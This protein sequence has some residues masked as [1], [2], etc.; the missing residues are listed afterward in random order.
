M[1]KFITLCAALLLTYSNA[2]AGEKLNLKAITGGLFSADYISGINPL[3][4][5]E[6]YARISSDGKQI[7]QYSFKT[8]KQVGILFDVSKLMLLRVISCRPMASAFSFR[9]RH[10]IYIAVLTRLFFTFT[11]LPAVSWRGFQ[12]AD[13]SRFLSGRPTDGR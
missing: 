13:R 9:R 8:G 12:T 11:R 4:G 1:K 5:G 2:M 3:S 7:V 10:N 6:L